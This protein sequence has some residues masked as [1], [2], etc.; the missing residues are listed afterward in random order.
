MTLQGDEHTMRSVLDTLTCSCMQTAEML[1]GGGAGA[2]QAA[3]NSLAA[4]L[5]KSRKPAALPTADQV[6]FW[7]APEKA[8]WMY[9]QGEHIRT[10]RKRWFV[11][12]QG[13]L[14]RFAAP[15]VGPATKPRGVVDLSSV[16]DVADGAAA[17]GRPNSIKL[18]T[19]TGSKCYLAE[20]ETAQV[21]WVSALEGAV[22]KLIKVIAGVDDEAEASPRGGGAASRSLSEALQRSYS[23]ASG[24]AAGGGGGAAAAASRS[25]G[26][27]AGGMVRIVNY[28]SGPSAPPASRPSASQASGAYGGGGGS[29]YGGYIN[30]DYGSV[31]GAQMAPAEPAGG[32]GSGSYGSIYSHPQ[33]GA[34]APGMSSYSGVYGQQ[35]QAA[36][37]PA[38]QQYHMHPPQPQYGGDYAAHAA[39]EY[40]APQGHVHGHGGVTLLDA[41][42][43]PSA[44]PS[45]P[46]ANPWQV[47]FT[48]DGRQYFYNVA[49]GLTTWEQPTA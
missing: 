16:A 48:S 11:L 24:V 40:G 33:H 25:G 21:E 5:R 8:G 27:G 7:K 22:A 23:A 4:L 20:S 44:P 42:T 14:F 36:P 19:A 28:D 1:Q 26:G 10:W 15:E 47:H 35:Q 39:A 6:E 34:P 37:P 38:Q 17:T 46:N 29:E 49:T 13:F 43:A 12:K 18:S 45:A 41:V 30:I 32:P 31:A 3:A 9:S 2:D